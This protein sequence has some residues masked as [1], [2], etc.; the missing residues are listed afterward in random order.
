MFFR[1]SNRQPLN[2]LATLPP[3]LPLLLCSLLLTAPAGAISASA[4][5]GIEAP[6]LIQPSPEPVDD[7]AVILTGDEHPAFTVFETPEPSRAVLLVIGSL[8][9]LSCYRRAWVNFKRP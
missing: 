4:D 2:R 8:L 3:L 9:V 5:T 1:Q 7:T 6:A